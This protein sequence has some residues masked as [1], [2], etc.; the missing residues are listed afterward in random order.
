MTD[1]GDRHKVIRKE[2]LE[3]LGKSVSEQ[4]RELEAKVVAHHEDQ[5]EANRILREWI[6]DKTGTTDVERAM[7]K[8]ESTWEIIREKMQAPIAYIRDLIVP[9][10]EAESD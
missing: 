3:G 9:A 1:F 7:W 4:M 2:I 6:T 10:E 5:R 8:L